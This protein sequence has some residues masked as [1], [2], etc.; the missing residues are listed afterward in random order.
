M[1][2]MRYSPRDGQQL[3][4]DFEPP[5]PS[6][7]DAPHFADARI[8]ACELWRRVAKHDAVSDDFRAIAAQNEAKLA[9]LAGL[10]KKLPKAQR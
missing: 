10:E 4:V 6:P 8:V 7:R 9:A 1:L 3:R 5:L 2:P